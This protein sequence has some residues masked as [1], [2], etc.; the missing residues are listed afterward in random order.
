MTLDHKKNKHRITSLVKALVTIPIALYSLLT[1]YLLLIVFVSG[2]KTSSDFMSNPIGL[3]KKWVLTTFIEAWQLS[4]FSIYFKNSIIITSFS[5]VMILI[6]ACMAAYGIARY[7]YKFSKIAYIYFMMGLMFPV[8]L[9]VLP[10]FLTLRNFG[11]LSSYLG[12]IVIYTATAQSFSVFLLVGFFR[13]LPKEIEEAAKIDGASDF[14]IFLQIMMPLSKPII[15]TVLILN[16]VGIWN[17]FLFP[18]VFILK[19]ELRTVPLGLIAF[20]GQ[21]NTKYSLLFAALA[22]TIIP[23]AVAYMFSSKAFIKG[24]ASGAIK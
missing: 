7:K 2:F 14:R 23:V 11:L 1:L 6:I 3:P 4:K 12:M 13:T 19:S 22:I 10:L 5:L 24:L 15:A 18:L 9:Y 20:F 8:Q 21:Y 17:D 16:L